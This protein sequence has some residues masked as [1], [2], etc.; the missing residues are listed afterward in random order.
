MICSMTIEDCNRR[1]LE[2][3]E[4]KVL[5]ART[6]PPLRPL[7][8]LFF[9]LDETYLPADVETQLRERMEQIV[10]W[11]RERN[12][13]KLK[14]IAYVVALLFIKD[15]FY[16]SDGS[17]YW[18]AIASINH[19]QPNEARDF[20]AF[21][22]DKKRHYGVGAPY[23]N[24]RDLFICLGI[25]NEQLGRTARD[26]SEFFCY[27]CPFL[28]VQDG[29]G[30]TS[31]RLGRNE[32]VAEWS[33]DEMQ[34]FMG[35][36]WQDLYNLR[37]NMSEKC[38]GLSERFISMYSCGSSRA[39]G[40]LDN[41]CFDGHPYVHALLRNAPHEYLLSLKAVASFSED[42]VAPPEIVETW[43]WIR[44][45]WNLGGVRSVFELICER[46]DDTE[47]LFYRM[48]GKD[49][50]FRYRG[51][52]YSLSNGDLLDY[53]PDIGQIY[54]LPEIRGELS[55]GFSMFVRKASRYQ[56]LPILPDTIDYGSELLLCRR[57]TEAI[58]LC[59]SS[60]ER[61]LTPDE[62]RA[63]SLSSHVVDV[64]YVSNE[65][66]EAGNR[67][68]DLFLPAKGFN[69]RL[70]MVEGVTLSGEGVLGQCSVPD[71][72]SSF[73]CDVRGCYLSGQ[74]RIISEKDVEIRA[75]NGRTCLTPLGDFASAC[76]KNDAPVQRFDIYFVP[77]DWRDRGHN[78]QD[79]LKCHP[80]YEPYYFASADRRCTFF[81]ISVSDDISDLTEM[82]CLEI[83]IPSRMAYWVNGGNRTLRC[84][85]KYDDFREWRA[86]GQF[87]GPKHIGACFD[88]DRWVYLLNERE[89]R[90]YIPYQ[91]SDMYEWLG[92]RSWNSDFCLHDGE[93]MRIVADTETDR[94]VLFD[95]FYT[96]VRY[97]FDVP[98][99]EGGISF[100]CHDKLKSQV[101][102]SIERVFASERE[103]LLSSVRICDVSGLID[104]GYGRCI[105]PINLSEACELECSLT[106][107]QETKS[108]RLRFVP[109]NQSWHE[110]KHWTTSL[111]SEYRRKLRDKDR[112]KHIVSNRLN[113]AAD[114]L[115]EN[116]FSVR[117]NRYAAPQRIRKLT[118]EG[119]ILA[120]GSLFH[121]NAEQTLY[122][123]DLS[124]IE[125]AS[126]AL[127]RISCFS[128]CVTDEK[129]FS[130]FWSEIHKLLK[131]FDHEYP[132]RLLTLGVIDSQDIGSGNKVRGVASWILQVAKCC[133][134]RKQTYHARHLL[135]AFIIFLL[136]NDKR[137]HSH[138][139]SPS[140]Y[141]CVSDSEF[142]DDVLLTCIF[143]IKRLSDFYP[144][145]TVL[146]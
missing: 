102:L 57:K 114:D 41:L 108:R 125:R 82:F 118:R 9:A 96:P 2:Y 26:Y 98:E 60:R 48:K 28:R 94:H 11:I 93:H 35:V 40:E 20:F 70:K 65:W 44:H 47:S 143:Y 134:R 132:A 87:S 105:I 53:V 16:N 36:S 107:S 76:C 89:D 42:Q 111:R 101:C 84:L 83:K 92:R 58:S 7:P 64:Y 5:E 33:D 54:P 22:L 46:V 137:N 6:S 115:F 56:A 50:T 21:L 121:P 24:S 145:K 17:D 78:I 51:R 86:L 61:I 31:A 37:D 128:L 63:T 79:V 104:K 27:H 110:R 100:Y 19:I 77:K 25:D 127:E 4:M 23:I 124:L 99:C 126:S 88:E 75:C 55:N 13:Q 144:S 10:S 91:Q 59:L 80:E 95:G 43:P 141:R 139:I 12:D 49:F 136:V 113:A 85:S 131:E 122:Q 52:A 142:N 133:Y 68:V 18:C 135:M 130:F 123:D 14:S 73:V 97:S 38:R 62:T 29:R 66:F 109:N 129:E 106:C 74:P 45:L 72:P 140:L 8:L 32:K 138:V 67:I 1:F 34:R 69:F 119:Y 30:A 120:D 71:V 116:I 117:K 103:V 146:L 81:P 39:K 90:E 112:I 15:I 3:A